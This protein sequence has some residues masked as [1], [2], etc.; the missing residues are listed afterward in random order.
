MGER[1]ALRDTVEALQRELAE[2]RDKNQILLDVF[3]RVANGTAAEGGGVDNGAADEDG[4]LAAADYDELAKAGLATGSKRIVDPSQLWDRFA[5]E[6]QGRTVAEDL[7]TV[8]ARLWRVGGG[9]PGCTVS[10]QSF[11]LRRLQT[12]ASRR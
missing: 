5:K 9:T 10:H 12:S 3:Q 2:M 11:L 8:S 4:D 6:R 1:D 7:L